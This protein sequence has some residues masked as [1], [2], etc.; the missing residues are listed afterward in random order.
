M[1]NK[2]LLVNDTIDSKNLGCQLVSHSLRRM[3]SK[4]LPDHTFD[5]IKL[6]QRK[7]SLKNEYEFAF[8]NGEGSLA[9][10]KNKTIFDACN[11]LNNKKIPVYLNN[12]TFD[13]RTINKTYNKAFEKDFLDLVSN[14]NIKNIS[15]RDPLS[16]LYLKKIGVNKVR[17]FPDAGVFYDS[18]TTTKK[19]KYVCFGG[20]SISKVIKR[21][22]KEN[23]DSLKQIFKFI[24]S[25]GYDVKFLDWPSSVYD[26][27]FMKSALDGIEI[28]KPDF[29]E[30][31]TIVGNS[32]LNV[33]GRHHG[34]V[35]SYNVGTPFITFRANMWK[36]E[37][38]S[39]LYRDTLSNYIEDIPNSKNLET[40]LKRIELELQTSDKQIKNM[41]KIKNKIKKYNETQVKIL[42]NKKVG[43]M[44]DVYKS[45]FDVNKAKEF[46]SKQGLYDE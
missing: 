27:E 25:K 43:C 45:S 29:K 24:S 2:F 17:L 6:D 21:V 13:P 3:F 33:T 15:V 41:N 39:L 22:K 36:T 14:D 1:K 46:L 4:H 40:Y 11:E 31:M 20:G 9:G 44:S 10:K 37:G 19:N 34:C 7:I 26:Y 23:I 35:M 8:V 5:S 38:D 28:I 18:K 30:Y 42:V 32:S 12:F 16:F